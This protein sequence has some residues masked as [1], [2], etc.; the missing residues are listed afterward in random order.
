MFTDNTD[1]ETSTVRSRL[2]PNLL[3]EKPES[4]FFP[5]DPWVCQMWGKGSTTT[6]KIKTK[7]HGWTNSNMSRSECRTLLSGLKG[8]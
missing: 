7:L 8:F 4:L 6:E 2:V 5:F 1:K 3:K